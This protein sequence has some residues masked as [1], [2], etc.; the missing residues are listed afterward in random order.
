MA[1]EFKLFYSKAQEKSTQICILG[2]KT[3]H[4]AKKSGGKLNKEIWREN[5]TK[6]VAVKILAWK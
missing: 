5:K 2:L 3:Y 1:I 4:L 6:K